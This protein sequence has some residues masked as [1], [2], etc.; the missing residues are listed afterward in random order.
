[1]DIM[2]VRLLDTYDSENNPELNKSIVITDEDTHRIVIG[3]PSLAEGY[4]TNARVN[5]CNPEMG[6]SNVV[7]G[8]SRVNHGELNERVLINVVH[9]SISGF[10]SG[11]NTDGSRHTLINRRYTLEVSLRPHVMDKV[12]NG[13]KVHTVSIVIGSIQTLLDGCL[14]AHDVTPLS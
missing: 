12:K 14:A 3:L 4:H 6:W 11:L 8:I 5:F 7:V 9:K 2:E 1:M 10:V 13:V